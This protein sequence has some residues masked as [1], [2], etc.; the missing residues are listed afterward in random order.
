MKFKLGFRM[1]KKGH[2]IDFDS[3]IGVGGRLAAGCDF[4]HTVNSMV[5]KEWSEKEKKMHE[6][7]LC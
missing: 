3:S 7:T 2:L 5:Y 6:C 1:G 4:P